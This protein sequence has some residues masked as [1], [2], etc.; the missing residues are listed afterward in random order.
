M[1][2]FGSPWCRFVHSRSTP[3]SDFRKW[4]CNRGGDVGCF[5][6]DAMTEKYNA[7]K[8]LQLVRRKV[9]A[10]KKWEAHPKVQPYKDAYHAAKKEADD[11]ERLKEE[12]LL[13]FKQFCEADSDGED[14][15]GQA[16][17]TKK[18][19]LKPKNIETTGG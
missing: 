14:L 17:K 5:G 4:Y 8:H 12:K 16:A 2:P 15:P 10:R 3:G 9:D 11:H 18:R 1:A 7:D 19:L 13:L 6:E